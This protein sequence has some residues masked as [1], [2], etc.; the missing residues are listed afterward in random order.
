MA[1]APTLYQF[2]VALEHTDRGISQTLSLRTAR[3][4]SETMARV[5]LRVLAFLW[6][7]HERLAFAAG[8][9]DPDAPDLV[10][11]DYTGE[12]TQ[13]IRVGK[14]DPA[15]VQREVDQHPRAEVAVVFESKDK[16]D[17]FIAAAREGALKRLGS[18][19]LAA[20]DS[21]LV[22]AL[23]ASEDRRAKIAVTI[24]GD[25]LYIEREGKTLDGAIE[26]GSL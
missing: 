3:H 25:H 26:R 8:L 18:V 2:D 13:W 14:V 23:A 20:V 1:Q 15:K 4:P 22:D 12:I 24:A 10:A 17:A 7:W 16:M 19:S 11:T 9:S 21:S 5:W 6:L